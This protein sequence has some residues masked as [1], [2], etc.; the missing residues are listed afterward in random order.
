MIKR[1]SIQLIKYVGVGGTA[2]LVEWTSFALLIKAARVHYLA[3]ATISFVLATA[4]NYVLSVL[5]VFIRGRHPAHKELILLY[6][7]SAIGLFLNL[8]LMSIFVGVFAMQAMPSKIAA[9]GIIFFWNFGA[10]KMWVFEK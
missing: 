1:T 6:A 7:V 4:V 10:R 5:F 3:A 9:T 2:A 8:L